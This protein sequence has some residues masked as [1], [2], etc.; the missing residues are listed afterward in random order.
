MD[1]DRVELAPLRAL[2]GPDVRFVAA[3]DVDNPLCGPNGASAVYGP[4]KGADPAAV[5]LLDRALAHLAA[6]VARDVGVELADEP[7]A[8]AAGGLGFGLMAFLGAHL[9]P[10]VEVVMD[11]VGL[12]AHV[13]Q[14]D[15]V[16][17]G[18]GKLDAQSMSGKTVDGVTRAAAE[19]RVRAAV[20]CGRAEIDLGDVS[21]RSLVERFGDGAARHDTRRSLETMSEELAH[22]L[23]EG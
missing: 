1:L 6:V 7:G 11:A 8:G 12:R 23:G 19:A 15:L 2:V 16:L 14:A 5:A 3:S 22:D 9:R 4:Q 13:A 20:V 21:V 18:E 17:T 10:G